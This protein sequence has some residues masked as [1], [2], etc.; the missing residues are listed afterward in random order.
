MGVDAENPWSAKSL[1][2]Y[3]FYCCPECSYKTKINDTFLE[4]AFVKHPKSNDFVDRIMNN[5]I[6]TEVVSKISNGCR[7]QLKFPML[8]LDDILKEVSAFN[9]LK[10][11]DRLLVGKAIAQKHKRPVIV[12][13]IQKRKLIHED[14]SRG[15]KR[16]VP[17]KFNDFVDTEEVF[18]KKPVTNEKP[19]W[20]SIHKENDLVKKPKMK[21]SSTSV[22]KKSLKES[23]EERDQDI[24]DETHD[25]FFG[26][27]SDQDPDY[28]PSNDYLDNIIESY[29]DKTDKKND[30]KI[31]TSATKKKLQKSANKRIYIESVEDALIDEDPFFDEDPFI[32]DM[33][34]PYEEKVENVRKK[35]KK[36]PDFSDDMIEPYEDAGEK[37]LKE[38]TNDIAG[39]FSKKIENTERKAKSVNAETEGFECAYCYKVLETKELRINHEYEYHSNGRGRLIPILCIICDQACTSS[40]ALRKHMIVDHYKLVKTPEKQSQKK[41]STKAPEKQS[42]KKDYIKTKAPEKQATSVTSPKSPNSVVQNENDKESSVNQNIPAPIIEDNA[43]VAEEEIVLA[44]TVP[45]VSFIISEDTVG[46]NML[47]DEHSVTIGAEEVVSSEPKEDILQTSMR[48][49]EI[50]EPQ[51]LTEKNEPEVFHCAYCP[52]SFKSTT[53]RNTHEFEIH[54]NENGELLPVSCKDCNLTCSNPY[55][56]R[57]H[58][59]RHHDVKSTMRSKELQKKILKKVIPRKPKESVKPAIVQASEDTLVNEHDYHGAS[60]NVLYKCAYCNTGFVSEDLRGLHEHRKHSSYF[61]VLN[62]V[63]CK[64]CNTTCETSIV[65]RKHYLTKHQLTTDPDTISVMAT[66]GK[67][68]IVNLPRPPSPKRIVNESS[69]KN[70]NYSCFFCR[71]NEKKFAKFEDKKEHII[72]HHRNSDGNIMTASC[73]MCNKDFPDPFYVS[74]GEICSACQKVQFNCAYCS[75][76]FHDRELRDLHETIGHVDDNGLALSVTCQHC[77]EIIPNGPEYRMHYKSSHG[78]KGEPEEERDY[79]CVKCND[80]LFKGFKDFDTHMKTQHE[81]SSK[82]HQCDFQG[83]DFVTKYPGSIAKHKAAVHMEKKFKCEH[84]NMMYPLEEQL[85][86]HYQICKIKNK[87]KYQCPICLKNFQDWKFLM[88]HYQKSHGS[89]PPDFNDQNKFVCD[90]CNTIFFDLKAQ[91]DHIPECRGV[92]KNYDFKRSCHFCDKEFIFP[93][94]VWHYKHVHGTTPPGYE[95]KK[96]FECEGCDS[97]YFTIAALTTHQRKAHNV[98]KRE[99]CPHCNKVFKA[100]QSLKSHIDAVHGGIEKYACQF[101]GKTFPFPY[102]KKYHEKSKCPVIHGMK[103]KPVNVKK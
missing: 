73:K 58:R 78:D 64:L 69:N 83:C 66:P 2:D 18:K 97:T 16:K 102:T 34:E 82:K 37:P 11:S 68:K 57:I 75:E 3:I 55:D 92:D 53:A 24:N 46:Q 39:D 43:T 88:L 28:D 40:I 17:E 94:C 4:H 9:N 90:H 20:K 79:K 50:V 45:V 25:A 98:F 62:E 33:I 95:N 14:S 6:R 35:H 1:E 5:D 19:L 67:K 41:D 93:K 81:Q 70:Q 76:R 60:K 52:E 84:C 89:K 8:I 49:A 101:C 99:Q 103:K 36:N 87:F 12:P 96:Q 44:D 48:L 91:R 26:D 80:K 71:K 15:R 29:E 23:D 51:Q 21:A 31:E 85:T 7:Q 27:D 100:G 54:V 30:K 42:Q 47:I 38:I 32:D 86:K 59:M 56:Y 61:G 13:L 22:Q 10:E 63:I 77:Q 65:L 74:H 72:L